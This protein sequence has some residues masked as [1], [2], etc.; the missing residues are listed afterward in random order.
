MM[1]GVHRELGTVARDDLA[2][3]LSPPQL[4]EFLLRYSQNANELRANL[5]QLRF[6]NA[7]PDEFRAVFRAPASR[8]RRELGS[9]S[10]RDRFRTGPDAVRDG[11]RTA[12]SAPRS[13]QQLPAASATANVGPA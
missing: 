13:R 9:S 4:E 5:G 7:T 3:V 1:V 11:A 2:R 10:S 6:F 12:G 8:A